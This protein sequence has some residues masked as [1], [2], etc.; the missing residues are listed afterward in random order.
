MAFVKQLKQEGFWSTIQ[1]YS[2]LR[3]KRCIFAHPQSLTYL[4]AYLDV[5]LLDY[6]Y[7]TNKYDKPLLD[8]IRVDACKRSFCIAFVWLYKETEDD[9]NQVF[10]IFRGLLFTYNIRLLSVI[11]IDYCRACI[12][13]LETRFPKVIW[14]LYVWHANKA[15]IRYCRVQIVQQAG[16]E[17]WDRFFQTWHSVIYASNQD[18]YIQRLYDLEQQAAT[19][20]DQF[21][22]IQDTQLLHKERIVKAQTD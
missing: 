6:T 11:L 5:I 3:L 17:T 19:F 21:Q 1:R 8:I 4:R 13:A 9:F 18:T 16:G 7:K 10:R 22:F 14:L 2:N 20:P 12:N 15:I